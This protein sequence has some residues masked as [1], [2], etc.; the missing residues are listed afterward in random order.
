MI[1]HVEMIVLLTALVACGCRSTMPGASRG[2]AA[3]S[4]RAQLD[5]LEM[6]VGRWTIEGQAKMAGVD[7][8]VSF[9]GTSEVTWEG[10]RSYVVARG[11]SDMGDGT[12]RHGLAAITYDPIHRVYRDALV[13]DTGGVSIATAHYRASDR[14]WHL[15]ATSEGPEGTMWWTGTV[16]FLDADSKREHWIGST[17][18]G[19]VKKM[20]ITKT[21]QRIAN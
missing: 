21:E 7:E 6:F 12:P 8:P 9:T 19:L 5:R 15:R 18:C 16:T 14:T 13:N 20:E 3:E 4:V 1:K 11:V 2:T 17:L 10:G